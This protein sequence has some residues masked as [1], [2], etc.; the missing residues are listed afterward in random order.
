MVNG[1][2]AQRGYLD[3]NEC[4]RNAS[5]AERREWN[6]GHLPRLPGKH[7][8]KYPLPEDAPRPSCDTCPGYLIALPLVQEALRAHQWWDK[9]QLAAWTGD[10]IPSPNLV[11]YVDVVTGAAAEVDIAQQRDLAQKGGQG[12]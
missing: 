2:G 4:M 9:G 7:P 11:L 5:P 3:C 1:S 6:C 12:E 8:P 10:R